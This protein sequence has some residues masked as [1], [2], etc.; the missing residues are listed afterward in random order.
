MIAK[1]LGVVVILLT[2]AP[3]KAWKPSEMP[4]RGKY[5]VSQYSLGVMDTVIFN[6]QNG[7]CGKY[8]LPDDLPEVDGYVAG[9]YPAWIGRLVWM[10]PVDCAGRRCDVKKLLI[11]DCG[12]GHMRPDGLTGI[13]WMEHYNIPFEISGELALQWGAYGKM[14]RAYISWRPMET[15]TSRLR[16]VIYGRS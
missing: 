10:R 1:L 13:Q 11:V 6:R 7:C 8:N 2:M 16:R 3:D 5:V 12:G 14:I 4:W 15:R 9:M